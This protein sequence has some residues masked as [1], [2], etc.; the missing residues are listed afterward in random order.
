MILTSWYVC[1]YVKRTFYVSKQPLISRLS[2]FTHACLQ[3][4]RLGPEKSSIKKRVGSEVARNKTEKTFTLQGC[5][6]IPEKLYN[7]CLN[8][9]DCL[10]SVWRPADN[11]IKTN[12]Q[13]VCLFLGL[14][15]VDA[16]WQCQIAELSRKTHYPIWTIKTHPHGCVISGSIILI[17]L[18]GNLDGSLTTIDWQHK[19]G[20]FFCL[21][22][23]L[24]CKN[25][26]LAVNKNTLI[27]LKSSQYFEEEEYI[28]AR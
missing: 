28:M 6:V 21:S 16:C 15:R 20:I 11:W 14:P 17:Y 22:D 3:I 27:L 25:N 26:K 1:S 8:S 7:Y 23:S 4:F 13:T 19:V 2:R 5:A 9:E 18:I 10:K 12:G 24:D